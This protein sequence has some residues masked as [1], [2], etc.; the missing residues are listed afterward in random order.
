M[1]KILSRQHFVYRNAKI[2]VFKFPRIRHESFCANV[3]FVTKVEVNTT[4]LP[5]LFKLLQKSLLV[6]VL[7]RRGCPFGRFLMCP[8]FAPERKKN[9]EDSFLDLP[10]ASIQSCFEYAMAVLF[11]GFHYGFFVR[12]GAD[13]ALPVRA[14]LVLQVI[15]LIGF[16]ILIRI[17]LFISVFC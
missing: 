1:P 17:M 7:L 5:L 16:I 12:F 3:A 4:G 15:R 11:D 8:N 13:Y 6:S 9:L 10:V 2:L 14:W